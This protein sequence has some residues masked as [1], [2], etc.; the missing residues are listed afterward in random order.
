LGLEYERI[1]LIE[2]LNK[3]YIFKSLRPELVEKK[4]PPIITMIKYKNHKLLG[5]SSKEIPILDILLVK[6]NNTDEKLYSKL[7]RTKKMIIKIRK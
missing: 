1:S 2:Y 3:K 7:N 5:V 6:E 4:E